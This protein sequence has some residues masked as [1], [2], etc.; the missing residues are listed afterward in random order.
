MRELVASLPRLA[1]GQFLNDTI[2]NTLCTRTRSDRL[3]VIDSHVV[4]SNWASWK[5][6]PDWLVREAGRDSLLLPVNDGTQHFWYRNQFNSQSVQVYDSVGK[7]LTMS[8]L[9]S[10]VAM[11]F[12]QWLCKLDMVPSVAAIK[13]S[14]PSS[15]SWGP[16]QPADFDCGIHIVAAAATFSHGSTQNTPLNDVSL[17][18]AFDSNALR[19]EFSASLCEGGSADVKESEKESGSRLKPQFRE[20]ADYHA[21]KA[22]YTMRQPAADA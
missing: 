2:I 16:I 4:A 17:P 1:P 11:S 5:R 7:D 8:P 18:K 6:T 12:L 20:L 15:V 9:T 13:L 19:E 10:D 14:S 22:Q 3:G 21:S